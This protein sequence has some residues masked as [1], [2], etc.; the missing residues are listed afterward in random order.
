MTLISHPQMKK[1]YALAREKQMDSDTLHEL[2]HVVT[3]SDSIKALSSQQAVNV[4]D[5]LTGGKATGGAGSTQRQ[6][7]MIETLTKEIGMDSDPRRLRR[8]LEK[9][10]GVS[11]PKYLN[12][13]QASQ[14]IEALKSMKRRGEPVT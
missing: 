12:Q 4:I 7:N 10:H 9:Q 2:V 8:F 11:H 6:R 13:K 1:I 14:T 5:R 3:G